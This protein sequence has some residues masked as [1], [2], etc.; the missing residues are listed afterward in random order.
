M[1]FNGISIGFRMETVNGPVLY[2]VVLSADFVDEAPE[3]RGYT[4]HKMTT[5]N[6]HA[7]SS[8]ILA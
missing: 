8:N 1:Q 6:Y 3:K 7:R 2:G 5:E 4:Y